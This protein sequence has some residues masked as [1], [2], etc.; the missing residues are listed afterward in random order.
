MRC[1]LHLVEAFG[2][3]KPSIA[4]VKLARVGRRRGTSDCAWVASRCSALPQFA[5]PTS[6]IIKNPSYFARLRR[7]LICE[8]S[9]FDSE[10]AHQLNN[11]RTATP[12]FFRRAQAP[13]V[14]GAATHNFSIAVF[15]VAV[16]LGRV[17]SK[18]ASSRQPAPLAILG[19]LASLARLAARR[20]LDS[21]RLLGSA[22]ATRALCVQRRRVA[23]AVPG[24]GRGERHQRDAELADEPGGGSRVGGD[25]VEERLDDAVVRRV[26]DRRRPDAAGP[27]SEPGLHHRRTDH[28]DREAHELVHL[29]SVAGSF[30]RS[31][32]GAWLLDLAAG[33]MERVLDDTSAEEFTWA[34]EA[35]VSHSSGAGAASGA[36]G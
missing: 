28:Q 35:V 12:V 21:L 9:R 4:G 31:R 34:P 13:T 5:A 27:H 29:R 7:L 6:E 23:P 19:G 1:R 8:F 30:S 33:S 2:A 14:A 25:P 10:A 17:E 26:H 16:Q 24:N 22:N 15:W 11:R 20:H 32:D 18:N 36:C 3:I